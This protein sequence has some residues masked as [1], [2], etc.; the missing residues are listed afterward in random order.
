MATTNTDSAASGG[1]LVVLGIV[2]ALGIGV[3]LFS[4]VGT[5]HRGTDINVQMEAP[6]PANQ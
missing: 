3:F 1:L 4:Y 5:S 2:V 6:R